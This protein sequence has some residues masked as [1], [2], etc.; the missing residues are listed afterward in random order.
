MI[1]EEGQRAA[2][3]LRVTV[4]LRDNEDV[5]AAKARLERFVREA[6]PWDVTL[7]LRLVTILDRCP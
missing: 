5:A 6:L 3:E 1:V 2:I 4:P 7:S